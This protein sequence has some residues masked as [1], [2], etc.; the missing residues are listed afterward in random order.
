[1]P[2]NQLGTLAG[3]GFYGLNA[4]YYYIR[5]FVCFGSTVQLN[6]QLNCLTHIG[7]NSSYE[8]VSNL[9]ITA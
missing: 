5:W 4:A 2:F 9:I 3:G 7:I 8:K 1:M 6:L